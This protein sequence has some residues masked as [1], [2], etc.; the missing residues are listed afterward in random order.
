MPALLGGISRILKGLLDTNGRIKYIEIPFN[1]NIAHVFRRGCYN[2]R[3][4]LHFDF[5]WD[6]IFVKVALKGEI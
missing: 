5:E 6:K 1:S 3:L 2:E 4:Q